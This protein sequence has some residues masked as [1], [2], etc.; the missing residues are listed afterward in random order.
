MWNQIKSVFTTI[1]SELFWILKREYIVNIQSEP[2][3]TWHMF[4]LTN[5]I[6][7]SLPT[8]LLADSDD[9]QSV[10]ILEVCLMLWGK[11]ELGSQRAEAGSWTMTLVTKEY[12]YSLIWCHLIIPFVESLGRIFSFILFYLSWLPAISV[13]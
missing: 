2:G 8:N 12:S 7:F 6:T 9:L 3:S 1:G 11:G 10:I 4:V 13:L 5:W